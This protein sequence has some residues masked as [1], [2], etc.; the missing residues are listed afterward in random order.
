MRDGVGTAFL[1]GDENLE[2][3]GESHCPENLMH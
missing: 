1:E 2:V 3:V